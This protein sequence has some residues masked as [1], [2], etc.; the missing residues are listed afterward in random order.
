MKLGGIG[1]ALAG[2][3]LIFVTVQNLSTL[4][5][6]HLKLPQTFVQVRQLLGLYQ[7]WTMFAPYPELTSPRPIIEGR[8]M[9]GQ[10][11]DVYNGKAG[12]A[13][14][15]RPEVVSAVYPNYRWRK[16]LSQLEDRSYGDDPQFLALAYG[17]YLCRSWN[18]T[19]EGGN[20]LF[21]F[22]IEFEVELTLP[23]GT[24]KQA[25]TRI[26]WFHDCFG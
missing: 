9:N 6:L 23:P 3:A 26:V 22:Q 4:P 25:K 21:T 17:R 11:V 1:S 10:K 12:P 5:M 19:A 2:M 8:M 18:A 16:F 14:R 7:N 24:E 20:Q 13:D 15:A